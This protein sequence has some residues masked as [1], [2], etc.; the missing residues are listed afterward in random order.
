MK[1]IISIAAAAVIALSLAG[2]NKEDKQVGNK[3]SRSWRVVSSYDTTEYEKNGMFVVEQND[4]L[5][6]MDLSTMEE[7]PLCDDPTCKHQSGTCNSFGKSNHPFLYND[8]LYYFKNTDFYSV[9][10]EYTI[11]SQ[12]WQCSINGADEKQVAAFSELTYQNYDRLLLYGDI[13]YMCMDNQL[14]DKDFKELEPSEELVS[15]DLKSGEVKNYGEVVK[16]YSCGSWIY[17]LWNGKVIFSTSKPKENLPYMEKVK[18]FAEE[19]NLSENEAITQY[20]E[21]Y[22]TECFQ[23]DINSG[24]VSKCETPEPIGI[25]E[26]FYYYFKG[27]N[28]RYFDTKGKEHK[29]DLAAVTDS[30]NILNGYVLFNDKN[31]TY[32]F[33]ETD[34]SIKKLDGLYDVAAIYEDNAIISVVNSDG[35]ISY[36]KKAL[37]EMEK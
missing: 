5:S 31:C 34:E 27:E 30:I 25:S 2:C 14:Y 22:I 7:A 15:C 35:S 8:K 12:L 4:S 3:K 18:K 24:E 9:G 16:G 37:S 11:D 36:E 10:D 1:R 17:G 23:L 28:L 29:I 26:K 20:V 33:D 13:I 19:N 32:L 6:F 21:E